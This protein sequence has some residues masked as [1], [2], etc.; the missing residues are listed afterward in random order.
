MRH[1]HHSIETNGLQVR[2]LVPATGARVCNSCTI[3]CARSEEGEG[4]GEGE[5]EGEEDKLLT[6]F[7]RMAIKN[8]PKVKSFAE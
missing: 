2:C 1:E 8:Q 4:E 5:S 3:P 6:W 7:V